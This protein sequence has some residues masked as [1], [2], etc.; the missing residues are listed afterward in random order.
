M[1][2]SL[3]ALSSGKLHVGTVASQQIMG[4]PVSLS[5][6]IPGTFTASGPAYIGQCVGGDLANAAL[7]VGPRL[8]PTGL[9]GIG[10]PTPGIASLMVLGAPMAIQATGGV[11]VIGLLNVSGIATK[12]GADVK[13]S[14]STTGGVTVEASSTANG[15][16]NATAGT[17]SCAVSKAALGSFASVSAPFKQFDIPHPT[18]GKGWRLAYAAL[19]GPEMGVYYRGKT[20]EK[21]IKLPE[22]WT[23]LVHAESITVQ[24]TP[25]GKACSSLHVKK[26]EDNAITVGHQASDLEYFYIIHGERKDLGDLIVE[27]RGDKP[28]DFKSSSEKIKRNGE[29]II[30]NGHKG[31]GP[32]PLNPL[33]N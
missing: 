4:S 17:I 24:L 10:V 25:I 20:K 22:Y 28:E 16:N 15:R 14:V 1:A 30:D 9:F 33:G 2:A 29:V 3:E 13:A 23:E 19:E 5:S 8:V 12:A 6:I 21:I 32:L 31:L 18:K 27:Y 7:S 11:N 26:I